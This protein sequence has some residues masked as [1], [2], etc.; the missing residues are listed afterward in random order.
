LVDVV[1]L[2]AGAFIVQGQRLGS[3]LAKDSTVRVR[4]RFA[5]ETV[6][7][8]HPGQ[9]AQLKLDGYPWTIYGTVPARVTRV[10][11]E[12]GIT[13]T[14]EAI[15]NT[16]RVELD[17]EAPPDPRII[18]EH[19]LTAQVEIEVARVSPAELLLRALGEWDY[20]A[21]DPEEGPP[22]RVFQAQSEAR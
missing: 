19:G 21:L 6:G 15:P 12:P 18:L 17:I 3:V 7:V 9:L 1:E 10:G 8:I 4:A 5:R 20:T 11:T 13:A 2:A 16:V 14:P 22:V